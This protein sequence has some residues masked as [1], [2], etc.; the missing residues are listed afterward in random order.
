[1]IRTTVLLVAYAAA[2]AAEDERPA[3]RIPDPKRPAVQ[4][5]VA[6][7]LG[8][9]L[10]EEGVDRLSSALP[11]LLHYFNREIPGHAPLSSRDEGMA[12]PRLSDAVL[13]YMTGNAA[14]LSASPAAKAALGEYL[15]GG[16]LLFA[17]DVRPTNWPWWRRQ[18]A[19]V[20]GTPFDRQFKQ[21]I[22]DPQVLGSS[23]WQPMPKSH[24]FYSSY[25]QF[26]D[27]PPLS[28]TVSDQVTDLEML[29]NRGRV[30]VIFS[31]LSITWSWGDGQAQDHRRA[32]Q[33]GTNLLIF[34]LTQRAAG[35]ALR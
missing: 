34:A 1:M 22:K 33:F 23:N 32:L 5:S 4:S 35:A 28:A 25:F 27:G 24:P 9:P 21:L 2:V 18:T 17:E 11:S 29:E 30:S 10:A 15:K 26:P 3:T 6:V 20:R 7:A 8:Y 16:G 13:V 19:G 31:D 12:Q 14:D